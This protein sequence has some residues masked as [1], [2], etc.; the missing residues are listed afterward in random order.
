MNLAMHCTRRLGAP[1]KGEGLWNTDDD[2]KTHLPDGYRTVCGVRIGTER[3]GW[4]LF[5]DPRLRVSDVTCKRCLKVSAAV[6][7]DLLTERGY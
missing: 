2:T 5:T 3:N 4:L 6:E 1:G 7:R